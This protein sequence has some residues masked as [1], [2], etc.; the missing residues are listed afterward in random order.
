MKLH[1]KNFRSIKQLDLELAPI[2]VLYGHNGTGKSSV[3]YAPLTL[4]NIVVNPD[5]NLSEFFNYGFTS[6]GEFSEVVFDH[7]QNNELELGI[8]LETASVNLLDHEGADYGGYDV[9]I[10]YR[11]AC[12]SNSIGSFKFKT[13][14]H[15][16][17]GGTR[18]SIDL[19][20]VATPPDQESN[21]ELISEVKSGKT[22]VWNGVATN[23]VAIGHGD[24]PHDVADGA[25]KML[26]LP[27]EELERVAFVPL[28]RGFY[29][30]LYSLQKVSPMMATEQEVT[31]MLA[32][33]E[34]LEYKIGRY[35]E[36][37]LDR[38]FRVRNR[39]GSKNFSLNSIDRRTGMGAS[40]VNEGFGVNQ[41]VYMLAKV[42]H[43]DSGIVCIEE[44]EIHLHPTAIR[45]LA[46]TLADIVQEEPTKHLIISTHSEQFILS[47]LALVAED[48]YSPDNLAIYHVTKKGKESEF[49][50]QQ[51]NENGQVEGGLATFMEGE[52][53]D[54]KA[55][56]GV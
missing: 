3:L 56:L 36:Q 1:I 33:D 8:S 50:R 42:L 2:T 44:P 26:N 15:D 12:L 40:L 18:V 21:R 24:V 31:S 10:D 35:M 17:D 43:P 30:P 55:F 32:S 52:L 4:K 53:E 47:L 39:I 49:Q 23:E 46:R 37:I 13:L 28:G 14:L 11:F 7:N 22:F 34:H 6:L 27:T 29:Q 19:M 16:W 51:V 41:L 25:M 54:M 38:D 45:R 5:Q 48:T 20:C 9:E